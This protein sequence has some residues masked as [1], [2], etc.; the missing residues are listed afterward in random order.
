MRKCPRCGLFNPENAQRCDC[1]YDFQKGTVK[2]AYFKQELPGEIKYYVIAIVV[3]QLLVAYLQLA[4][5]KTWRFILVAP[6]VIVV[7]LLYAELVRKRNWARWAL[8][9]LTFPLG[10]VLLSPKVRLYCLQP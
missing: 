10:L 5:G 1:G 3:Y 4:Q 2:K 6:W 9:F 8:V 7:Y